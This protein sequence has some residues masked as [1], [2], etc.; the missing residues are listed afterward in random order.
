MTTD[1]WIEAKQRAEDE[2][3]RD[4]QLGGDDLVWKAGSAV[5]D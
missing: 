1:I 4:A 5:V 2:A 3:L